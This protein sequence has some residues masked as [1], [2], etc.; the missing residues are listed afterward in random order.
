LF[1][2]AMHHAHRSG[3]TFDFLHVAQKIELRTPVKILAR[4]T[5]FSRV[6]SHPD[7]AGW[8]PFFKSQ[9]TL[10]VAPAFR[11]AS[12]TASRAGFF[13]AR[14]HPDFAGWVPFIYCFSIF[15]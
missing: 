7:F 5:R 6:A 14:P 9:R 10:R 13:A 2:V 15:L 11:S 12:A 1:K 4:F 3:A 8:V